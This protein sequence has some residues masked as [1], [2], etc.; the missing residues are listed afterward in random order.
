MLKRQSQHQAGKGNAKH[1]A[2]ISQAGKMVQEAERVMSKKALSERQKEYLEF[3]TKFINENKYSPSFE[4]IAEHTG[5]ARNAAYEAMSR[6]RAA[7]H[8][9]FLPG[10]AR[11]ITLVE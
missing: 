5:V 11:T 7:G 3:I 10:R 2:D 4:E 6:L 1:S 9:D 8:I